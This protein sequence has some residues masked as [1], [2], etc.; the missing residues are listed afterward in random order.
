MTITS[1]SVRLVI[2]DVLF[3]HV[4]L[5]KPMHVYLTLRFDETYSLTPSSKF[6]KQKVNNNNNN[7]GFGGGG[8]YDDG[9][10]NGST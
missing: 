8:N 6:A 4:Y 2:L 10:D 7:N 5:Y 1:S 9:I 3:L